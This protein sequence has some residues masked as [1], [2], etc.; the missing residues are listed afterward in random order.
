MGKILIP[1]KTPDDWRCLLADPDKHWRTGYS[2]KTLAHCWQSVGDFPHSAR[3]A[4]ESSNTFAGL[5]LL[6]AIPEVKTPL[7]GGSRPTQTD[8]WALARCDEGLISIAV[9][10]K[11]A[12][13]F[14]PTLG[15]WQTEEPGKQERLAFLLATLGLPTPLG[16]G[17][18]Y[19]LLHRTAAAVLEARRFFARHAIMLV[20]AFGPIG[21][22]FD[23]YFAFAAL[24]GV[25]V[26]PGQVVA[27]GLRS[28]VSL[29][30]GWCAG[31]DRFLSA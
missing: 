12:E 28:G 4:L 26:S 17:I 25:S 5:E 31:E 15:E 14:G 27:V 3:Q 1:T 2:A 18:R 8:L 23:D 11:V 20:H 9:E 7:P 21:N 13:S 22:S 19:Q 10:G 24:F 16:P 6:L 30:L 29:H